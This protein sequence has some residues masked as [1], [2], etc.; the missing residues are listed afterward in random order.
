MKPGLTILDTNAVLRFL[1]NDIEEQA[2]AV[3][4]KI[5][6]TVCLIPT[7]II[8]E[9][10]YVL[11]GVYGIDRKTIADRIEELIAIEDGIVE[12]SRIV[13]FAVGLFAENT[14][15]DSKRRGSYPAL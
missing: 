12:N 13:S 9:V 2:V 14:K 11:G 15:L 10:V 8:A 1:L 5:T 6:L 3:K 7:E 4:E